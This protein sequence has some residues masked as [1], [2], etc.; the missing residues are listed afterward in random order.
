MIPTIY[1]MSC[2]IVALHLTWVS[3][4]DESKDGAAGAETNDAAAET[5][6]IAEGAEGGEDDDDDMKVDEDEGE[7]QL[8]K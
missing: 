6:E 1:F 7:S 2:N 5:G 3:V 4:K 8:F